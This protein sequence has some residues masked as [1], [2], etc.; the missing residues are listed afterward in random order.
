MKQSKTI[1]GT[2]KLAP[3]PPPVPSGIVPAFPVDTTFPAWATWKTV[4]GVPAA[5]GGWLR[6]ALQTANGT[7]LFGYAIKHVALAWAA[8]DPN[9]TYY[10]TPD[11][12]V[13][14]I[15]VPASKLKDWCVAQFRTKLA[16]ALTKWNAQQNLATEFANDS[17]LYAGDT[18]ED[19][20]MVLNWFG[21][22]LTA[23]EHADAAMILQQC[24]WNIWN[25]TQANWNGKLYTWSGW[26]MGNPTNNYFFRSHWLATIYWATHSQ[27]QEWIDKLTKTGQTDLR[28]KIDARYL[29][30]D[31]GGSLEGTGYGTAM[32]R[33]FQCL[34]LTKTAFGI[35][36]ADECQV[37]EH[38]DYW[39]W[40]CT[41]DAR[42]FAPI[43]DTPTIAEK[44][45]HESILTFGIMLV[46]NTPQA[47]HARELLNRWDRSVRPEYA[48]MT[49]YNVSGTATPTT[50]KLYAATGVGHTFIRGNNGELLCVQAGA[51]LESHDHK[52]QG[53]FQLYLPSTT[54]NDY[55]RW[56]CRTANIDSHSGII[57]S[58]QYHNCVLFRTA[59]GAII[60]PDWNDTSPPIQIITDDGD[61][62]AISI[63]LKRAFDGAPDV[64]TYIRTITFVRSQ[65]RL[66]VMDSFT[67]QNG[68]TGAFRATFADQPMSQAD[69]SWIA[70]LLRIVPSQQPLPPVN[71]KG[72]NAA[73][74]FDRDCWRFE[75]SGAMSYS[76]EL[77]W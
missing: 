20:C 77:S 46:P 25:F 3:L 8:L 1:S 36:M 12:G 45:V 55:Q 37:A 75:M 57:Q 51:F 65:K 2:V 52:D 48:W 15:A 29:Y 64:L 26:A 23:Q 69:G 33:L 67:T 68:V 22:A 74:V 18:V 44:D 59:A 13:T 17:Y 47:A 11:N 9:G 14:K 5:S 34:W 42:S 40:A 50:G 6:Y 71:W 38:L 30:E 28:P 53:E 31:G 72:E 41:P 60:E 39:C 16:T 10:Y 7:N 43:G 76:L 27:R 58:M 56:V 61:T 24:I 73:V 35:D 70:G 66:R 21:D 49:C 62:A 63:D 4:G 19:W 32:W 54:R